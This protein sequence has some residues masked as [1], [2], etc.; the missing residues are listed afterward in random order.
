[1]QDIHIQDIHTNDIYIQDIQREYIQDIYI[2]IHMYTRMYVCVCIYMAHSW[3]FWIGLDQFR[4]KGLGFRPRLLGFGFGFRVQG[5]GFG[6]RTYGLH[7]CLR[8]AMTMA[9]TIVEERSS[10]LSCT[11]QGLGLESFSLKELNLR[12]AMTMAR[13]SLSCTSSPFLR[14]RSAKRPQPLCFR[15]SA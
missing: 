3:L 8:E 10:S 13:S 2:Y 6:F 11:S 4:S 1:M 5:L 12:E 7:T 15:Q 9:M 14:S